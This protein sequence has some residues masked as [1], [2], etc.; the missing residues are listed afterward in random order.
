VARWLAG[1][2]ARR[3][4]LVGRGGLPERETWDAETDPRVRERI[5]AVR[6]LEAAGVTVAVVP[7]DITDLEAAGAALSPAALGLPPIRGVVHLAGVLDNRLLSDLDEA[8]LAKVLGPKA[9][10]AL[11]LDQLFPAGSLDFFVLFSSAGYLFQ[12]PGQTSY[13]A[14][15]AFLDGFARHRAATGHADTFSIAWTVWRGLGMSAETELVAGELDE[16]GHS[17]LSAVE[18]LRAWEYAER[19][20]A[21]NYAVFKLKPTD[22]A[23][24][25]LPLA[26]ELAAA[27]AGSDADR[28]ADRDWT[29][30]S[31][32]ELLELL[33]V[34]VRDAVSAEIKLPADELDAHQPLL[35]MGVDSVM[36]VAIRRRL[37]RLYRLSLPATL[38]WNSPTISAIAQYLAERLASDS[39]PAGVAA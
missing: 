31:T 17:D 19:Y 4:V 16:F 26:S 36:T 37:E 27:T 12:I 39:V 2:G 24:R 25:A 29:S 14:A 21:A 10:G 7:L 5:E 18:C 20:G 30:L 28:A 1:R 15:N 32:D 13:A 6:A 9:G 34:D 35:E 33:A 38:L 11:V 8:S 3:L 23:P 22:G